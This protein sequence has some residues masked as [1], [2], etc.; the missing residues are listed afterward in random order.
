MG[1]GA[2]CDAAHNHCM[3][4][5]VWFSASNYVQ[6]KL[7]RATP[8]FELEGKWYDFRGEPIEDG[9]KLFKT[10]VAK[11]EDVRAGEP[12]VFFKPEDNPR[13]KWVN[14]E[15]EALTSSRWDVGV[16]DSVNSATRTF[17][18]KAWPDPI[19]VDTARVIVEQKSH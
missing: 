4:D 14:V 7:F 18:T 15:E 1:K 17:T 16:P 2:N 10:R 6:G 8:A 19:D 12:I 11:I 5:G 3:R 13:D 9:T